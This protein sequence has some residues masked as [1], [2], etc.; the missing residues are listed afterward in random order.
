[1]IQ[2]NELDFTF[3]PTTRVKDMQAAGVP[4]G[5]SFRQNI[6]GVGWLG[7][8]RGSKNREN[9]MRLLDFSLIPERQVELANLSGDAPTSLDS[10]AK[11]DPAVRKWLPDVATKDNLFVNGEWWDDKLE[12]LTARLRS[13]S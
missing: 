7:V 3:T 1:M 8:L 9:A 5:Y 6:L 4:M 10:A 11:V 12:P 2:Q 13:G